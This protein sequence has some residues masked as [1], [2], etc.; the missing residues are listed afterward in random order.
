M[1][2][3]PQPPPPPLW[4]RRPSLAKRPPAC[5]RDAAGKVRLHIQT[6]DERRGCGQPSLPGVR[7]DGDIAV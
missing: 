2:I 4:T 1:M 5:H 6:I 3:L 7:R